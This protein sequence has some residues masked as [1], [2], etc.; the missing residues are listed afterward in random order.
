MTTSYEIG[1]KVALERIGL[2]KTARM[3]PGRVPAQAA[4][5]TKVKEWLR[6]KAPTKSGIRKFFFGD[7]RRF[8]EELMAGKAT[9]KGS[10]LRES[11][12][13]PDMLSKAMFYGLPLMEAG[14]IARDKEPDKAQ[15]IGRTLG[16]SALGLAAWRPFG[17]VGSM[18]ADT[19]GRQMGGA[20]G[21]AVGQ[22]IGTKQSPTPSPTPSP[23]QLLTN[24]PQDF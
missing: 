3:Y 6:S 14:S 18:A 1:R 15:R 23:T 4:R 20:V 24:P 11:F 10:V 19:L 16:G 21:R 9:G 5:L 8:G 13:A 22:R 12:R 2:T 17:L 7:P